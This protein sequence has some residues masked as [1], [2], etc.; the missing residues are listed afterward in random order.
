MKILALILGLFLLGHGA[1]SVNGPTAPP[2]HPYVVPACHGH[3]E[4]PGYESCHN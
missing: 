3:A 2:T 4:V 1:G